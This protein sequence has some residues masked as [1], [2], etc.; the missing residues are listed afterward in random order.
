MTIAVPPIVRLQITA[1][2][3]G[4]EQVV[5]IAIGP[6]AKSISMTP[7]RLADD[8]PVRSGNDVVLSGVTVTGL[9]TV[10]NLCLLIKLLTPAK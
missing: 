8:D 7:V 9:N 4:C 2:S 1:L 10:G 5:K 3:Y 6:L